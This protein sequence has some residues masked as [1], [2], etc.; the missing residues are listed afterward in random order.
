MVE[1][2]FTGPDS[3]R[4]DVKEVRMYSDGTPMIKMDNFAEIVA[5]ADTMILRPKSLA[6]FTEAMFLTNSI[7]ISGGRIKNLI[8]PY[9]P[10]ARQD[11]SNPTGD[12]LHTALSVATM[13]NNQYFEKVLILDPHSPVITNLIEDV[14]V[15]PLERVAGKLRQGYMAGYTGIIAA[16][17][18][19]QD[20]AKKF[21]KAM[22]KP[23]FYGSKTRDV[24]T[25]KLSGFDVEVLPQGGNFLVVDD[26]CDGGGTFIGLGEKI[27]EQGAFADLFVTH[28][29]FSKGVADLLKVYGNVYT[30]TSRYIRQTNIHTIP[31]ME[32]M[33]NYINEA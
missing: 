28:G 1:I 31:I 5:K 26:I 29:I 16:D 2:T 30:T 33:E 9:V 19:G 4:T 23:I 24:A 22:G 14:M 12:V 13:I 27:L 15:Y 10:G 8:L 32:D 17:K 11:R 18:G 20:R 21:A 6:S 25:G 7:W 3:F